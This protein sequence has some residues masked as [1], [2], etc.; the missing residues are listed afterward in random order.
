MIK[1]NFTEN[2]QLINQGLTDNLTL[3]YTH[4]VHDLDM[5]WYRKMRYHPDTVCLWPGCNNYR[6]QTGMCVKHFGMEA[7][8]PIPEPPPPPK[9]HIK[10]YKRRVAWA[11]KKQ[12][13]R[14]YALARWASR[15]TD[16]PLHVDHIIP[17]CGKKISG[18]H[19]ESN[20]QILPARHNL[21]K[22]NKFLPAY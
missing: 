11:N 1:V 8:M 21:R 17:L 7:E 5:K 4:T 9:P 18:L 12:I 2:Q 22:H 13:E 20:L 3:L 14:I 15:F 19:V 16:E 6:S 10:R